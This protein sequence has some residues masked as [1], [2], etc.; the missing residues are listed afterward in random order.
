MS[1]VNS[2]ELTLTFPERQMLQT[3][4][5]LDDLHEQRFGQNVKSLYETANPDARRKTDRLFRVSPAESRPSTKSRSS[6]EGILL[7]D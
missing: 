7:S 5:D 4:L 3:A 2:I 1:F 6:E